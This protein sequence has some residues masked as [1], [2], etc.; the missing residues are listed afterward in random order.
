MTCAGSMRE[1]IT[2]RP[3]TEAINSLGGLTDAGADGS[4]VWANVELLNPEN[5]SPALFGIDSADWEKLREMRL[6][7][8]T[9]RYRTDVVRGY[10]ITDGNGVQ[11]LVRGAANMDRLKRFTTIL[12]EENHPTGV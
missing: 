9:T 2:I 4:P 11:Y 6:W 8:F 3:T 12:A 5:I 1:Q 7:K 10:V